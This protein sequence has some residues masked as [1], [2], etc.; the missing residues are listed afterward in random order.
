MKDKGSNLRVDMAS[1]QVPSSLPPTVYHIQ[2]GAAG[3]DRVPDPTKSIPN[4]S[5]AQADDYD[6]NALN[7]LGQK[8]RSRKM[9]AIMAHVTTYL[10]GVA[11][12][13]YFTTDASIN[14]RRLLPDYKDK[15][16]EM[17][18][19]GITAQFVWTGFMIMLIN[20]TAK[21]RRGAICVGTILYGLMI[22]L[23]LTIFFNHPDQVWQLIMV[24]YACF[25]FK[26]MEELERMINA[27][28][29]LTRA[30]KRQLV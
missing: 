14:W 18:I 11:W 4:L 7:E 17:L 6:D 29:E 15:D 3:Q 30:R 22:C 20:G 25:I 16:E 9:T 12:I 26:T 21:G 28:N 23:G 5:I 13:Y 27:H 10:I 8:I 1:S 19:V 24:I 2:L